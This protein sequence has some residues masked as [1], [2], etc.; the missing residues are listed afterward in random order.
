MKDINASQI[1]HKL[2]YLCQMTETNFTV[3]IVGKRSHLTPLFPSEL[4]GAQISH[5][6]L[7][8]SY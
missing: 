6:M 7:S 3:N 8:M 1:G 2:L 4:R 5:K